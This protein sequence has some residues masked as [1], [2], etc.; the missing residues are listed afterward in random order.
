MKVSYLMPS[1]RSGDLFEAAVGS[2]LHQHHQDVE[3]VI[4][5]QLKDRERPEW[6][7]D[8]RV[9]WIEASHM[10]HYDAWELGYSKISGDI[11][12]TMG[13][14][15]MVFPE[16]ALLMSALMGDQDAVF[17][18][19]IVLDYKNRHM[20]T[21]IPFNFVKQCVSFMPVTMGT[22]GQ[23]KMHL[24]FDAACWKM[25]SLRA[26]GITFDKTLPYAADTD[27][28][29]RCMKLGFKMGTIV[30]PL[31]IIR[32]DRSTF[33]GKTNHDPGKMKQKIRE[34]NEINRRYGATPLVSVN[35]ERYLSR[36]SK[37][38]TEVSCK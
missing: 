6:L 19:Y 35:V 31:V 27:W 18:G 1:I 29:F 21:E 32:K 11:F 23:G 4:A 14:D 13:D 9:I 37:T 8:S 10:S 33:S 15:N 20:T 3:I 34:Y 36:L 24:H 25:S 5:N 30:S 12:C 26:H 28:I 7:D 22:Y 16:H 38:L 2:I 17:C